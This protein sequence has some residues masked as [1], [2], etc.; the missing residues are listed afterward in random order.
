MTTPLHG[1]FTYGRLPGPPS[2]G[3]TLFLGIN[4]HFWSGTHAISQNYPSSSTDSYT[5]SSPTP[6][7]QQAHYTTKSSRYAN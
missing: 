5:E 2:L 1:G 6:A 7:P 3:T 4:G